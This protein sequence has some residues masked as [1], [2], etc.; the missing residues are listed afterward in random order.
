MDANERT[1]VDV[2]AH[3]LPGSAIAAAA[4]ETDW[5]GSRIET[6]VLGRPEIVTGDYRVSM[7]GPANWESIEERITRM[8]ALGVDR[9][10]I[11]LNPILFRYYLD[12]GDA[13]ECSKAVNDE[14]A[15]IVAD[16]SRPVRRVRDAA[17]AGTCRR[18][19]RT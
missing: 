10:V 3:L 7:G 16:A 19:G 8:D 9:Q 1:V 12:Q 18:G 6:D 2:H 15:G 17:H 4:S 5:F 11:S 13:I 14:I